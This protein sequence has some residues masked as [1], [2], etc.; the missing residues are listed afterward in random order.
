MFRVKRLGMI[1]RNVHILQQRYTRHHNAQ[2]LDLNL[3]QGSN[4][5]CHSNIK[6]RIWKLARESVK[7]LNCGIKRICHSTTRQLFKRP[8]VITCWCLHHSYCSWAAACIWCF[9]GKEFVPLR[10][11]VIHLLEPVYSRTFFIS[12]TNLMSFLSD[13][14]FHKKN[15]VRNNPL[16]F[17]N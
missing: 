5:T 6:E 7:D 11:D 1:L 9:C 4:L 13:P 16:F 10:R 8:V 14:L 3:H 17:C 12:V 2:D 15:T